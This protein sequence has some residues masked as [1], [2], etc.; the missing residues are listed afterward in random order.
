MGP[1]YQLYFRHPFTAKDAKGLLA[2]CVADALENKCLKPEQHC[3]VEHVQEEPTQ[4]HE[5]TWQAVRL[6]TQ[7]C[8]G[9]L[10]RSLAKARVSAE[11]RPDVICTKQPYKVRLFQKVVETP[12]LHDAT[13]D[14]LVHARG[15]Q[16]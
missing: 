5:A 1:R 7:H 3:I 12:P 9:Y 4:R 11:G 13:L 16:V 8:N 2:G 15:K 6:T 10:F 14:E